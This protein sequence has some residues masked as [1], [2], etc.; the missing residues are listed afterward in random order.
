MTLANEWTK[1]RTR[2][3]KKLLKRFIIR[4]HVDFDDCSLACLNSCNTNLKCIRYKVRFQ[5]KYIISKRT[6]FWRKRNSHECCSL[7]FVIV[8]R[9]CNSPDEMT[10]SKWKSR[11]ASKSKIIPSSLRHELTVHD[12]KFETSWNAC[13]TIYTHQ[14]Q[15]K[16]KKSGFLIFV[17][18]RPF[19]NSATINVAAATLFVL[20]LFSPVCLGSL[21]VPFPLASVWSL[22]PVTR[23]FV[24]DSYRNIHSCECGA[25]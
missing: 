17:C 4:D 10:L 15:R 8:R 22:S 12:V 7:F 1:M 20:M 14:N 9:I 21:S 6:N 25:N 18:T 13:F 19:S 24:Y 3:E 2:W 5:C 11:R 23:V 16:K